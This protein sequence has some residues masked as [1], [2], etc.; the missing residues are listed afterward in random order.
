MYNIN[1][2]HKVNAENKTIMSLGCKKI[3]AKKKI[4]NGYI[5]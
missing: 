1:I 4:I 3:N 2:I 5:L